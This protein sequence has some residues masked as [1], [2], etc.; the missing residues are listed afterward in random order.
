MTTLVGAWHRFLYWL[1]PYRRDHA[2]IDSLVVYLTALK[3]RLEQSSSGAKFDGMGELPSGK[4]VETEQGVLTRLLV[5]PES[6]NSLSRRMTV[7]ESKALKNT[8][9]VRIH[10]HSTDDVHT[11]QII[12]VEKGEIVASVYDGPNGNKIYSAT[13]GANSFV[14]F[15]HDQW[16]SVLFKKGAEVISIFFPPL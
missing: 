11:N 14:T 1:L 2:S 10:N 9:Q 7:M 8:K 13:Y 15:T 6:L 12:L 4:W 16:H 5:T 3:Y